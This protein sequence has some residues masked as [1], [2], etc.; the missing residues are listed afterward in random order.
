MEAQLLARAASRNALTTTTLLRPTASHPTTSLPLS[1]K[2]LT[3]RH[4]S[5]TRRT[6][7]ALNVPP[8]PSF[9]AN[10]QGDTIIFNPPASAA[11]VYHTPFK[12]LPKSDPRRRT[13]LAA[14]FESSTTLTFNPSSAVPDQQQ[15]PPP[16]ELPP[17]VNHERYTADKYHLTKA[18]VEEMRRLRAEDP[19][20]WSVLKLAR[21]YNC[22]P[23]FVMLTT[24]TSE[25]YRASVRA[26]IDEA[27]RQWGPIRT[28]ARADRRK[29]M[30]MLYRGEI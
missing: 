26:R 21:R 17:R 28:K 30:E 12:F 15:Q 13:N 25:E 6:K 10:K 19:V 7:K 29:R 9:L 16:A 23:I 4:K 20:E 27:R 2:H 14:L 24:K 22:S 8:H 11:S 1:L 5:S 3:V 18:D